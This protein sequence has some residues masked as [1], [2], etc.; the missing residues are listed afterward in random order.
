[1]FPETHVRVHKQR[2]VPSMLPPRGLY[3]SDA[4]F[5][6]TDLSDINLSI[7]GVKSYVGPTGKLL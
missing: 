2:I 6:A 5:T 7:S 3:P 1:M 4:W